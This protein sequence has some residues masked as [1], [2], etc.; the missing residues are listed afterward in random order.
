MD[1]RSLL[2][3]VAAMMFPIAADADSE[4]WR[5]VLQKAIEEG[6]PLTLG[7]IIPPPD[8][9]SWV[10]VDTILENAPTKVP[11][12]QIAEYFIN[13]VPLKYQEAWPEPDL[14]HPTYANPLILRFFLTTNINN[15]AGDTTPWCSAFV[16]WCLKRA[17]IP[18]TADARSLS[19]LEW[20]RPVWLKGD[21]VLP[22]NAHRGDVAVFQRK[23]DP[24]YGHV[25]FFKQTSRTEPN[26]V[27]ILGGNQIKRRGKDQLHLID[28]SSL[29]VGADL[30]LVAIR[31]VEGMR[32]D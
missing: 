23:S 25:G 30:Q 20:G 16:N 4:D 28:I 29:R 32:S 3:S 10:E 11:P 12:F 15:P 26:Q 17:G 14:S 9:Q 6:S 27:E 1:R 7:H 19:Y 21:S 8:D 2:F 31:T 5:A 18:N 13:S 22:T 24:R